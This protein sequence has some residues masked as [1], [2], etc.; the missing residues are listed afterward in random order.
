M[1]V[2][3][4]AGF[5]FQGVLLFLYVAASTFSTRYHTA[6]FVMATPHY[7]LVNLHSTRGF[8]FAR[9]YRYKIG[10][11]V[12]FSLVKKTPFLMNLYT[13]SPMRCSV[14]CMPMCITCVTRPMLDRMTRKLRIPSV[15]IDTES[16]TAMF[17]GVFT[18]HL[19]NAFELKD[20]KHDSMALDDTRP[21]RAQK[22]P[23][24]RIPLR[25]ICTAPT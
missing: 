9:I 11:G 7:S 2:V 15:I 24:R 10:A 3:S 17:T 14:I 16:A 21:T 4:G 5:Q 25:F 22:T 1:W 6:D 8:P 19:P 23:Q 20:S 12:N 13:L 18:H